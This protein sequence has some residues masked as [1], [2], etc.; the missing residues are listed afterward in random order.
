MKTPA[1]VYFLDTTAAVAKG[2][3]NT[4]IVYQRWTE[5]ELHAA[6]DLLHTPDDWKAPFVATIRA[7]LLSAA[8]AAAEFFTGESLYLADTL[9]GGRWYTVKCAGYRANPARC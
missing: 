2:F 9:P 8:I 1:E 3:D 5:A 7:E 4:A 6:F